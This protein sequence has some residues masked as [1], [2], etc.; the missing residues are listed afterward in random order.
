MPPISRSI[1]PIVYEWLKD[2]VFVAHNVNFDYSFLRHQL[3][4]CG[5]ELNS[6]KLCTVR[7]SRKA[8]P[9]RAGI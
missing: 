7:L 3:K 9:E 2:A 8:F 1:A 6:K 5:F 4:T